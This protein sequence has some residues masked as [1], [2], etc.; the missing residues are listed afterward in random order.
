MAITFNPDDGDSVVIGGTDAT[1]PNPKYSISA[2]RVQSEQ[3]VLLD[4]IYNITVNGY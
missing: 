3:G 2:E 4:V 1:G